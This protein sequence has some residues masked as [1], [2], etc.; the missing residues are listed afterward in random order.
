M[1]AKEQ[2]Y[3]HFA[4]RR[5]WLA[6]ETLCAV[7]PTVSAFKTKQLHLG[8]ILLMYFALEGFLN[9][10]LSLRAP[11]IWQKERTFFLSPAHRGT[12]GKCLYLATVVGV[13]EWSRNERPLNT[14]RE[15][16][17]LRHRLVHPKPERGTRKVSFEFP[18][19]PPS[20]VSVIDRQL[21]S[22]LV[23][24]AKADFRLIARRL[25]SAAEET[26]DIRLGAADPFGPILGFQRTEM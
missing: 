14:V 7:I 9:W 11:D 15:V 6:A 25:Q 24:R 17:A 18:E 21:N 5:L 8:A 22:A 19:M 13:T 23:D 26:S 2:Y 3:E 1:K 4:H 10:L 20:H 16:E 12:F